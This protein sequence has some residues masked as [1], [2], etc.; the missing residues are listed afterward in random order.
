MALGKVNVNNLNLGQGPVTEIERHFL[1]VGQGDANIG[2]VLS[3][4]QDTDLDVALGINPSEL[5]T[6]IQAA[7]NNG[8]QGWSCS[9][10]PINT[11]DWLTAV[12]VAMD[13]ISPEAIVLVD[14]VADAV[15]IDAIQTKAVS[16]QN[17]LA[18]NV[19]FIIAM[20]GI[21]LQAVPPETWAI[22]TAAMSAIVTGVS[23]NRVLPVPQLHG[24]NV[25]ILAGRLANR[26][27]SIADSPMRIRTGAVL[28]LGAKPVDNDGIELSMAELAAL[29]A[30]RLSVPQWYP[31]YE[32]VYWGD[33]NL[34]EVTGG[35]YQVIEYL[36]PVDSAARKVRVL[37]LAKI[38]DRS[39]NNTAVSNKM[40]ESLF[41]APLRLLSKST[42]F[43][44]EL[45]PGEIQPPKEDAVQIVWESMTA[46]NIYLKVRPYSSPK[47][48]T[49]SLMLD[50]SN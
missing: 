26:A 11:A 14:P 7:K 47:D 42:S 9:A 41:A 21:D 27:A 25:G 44:G 29:D 24:N 32:G 45:L 49:A 15:S 46:V 16:I 13:V 30:M 12:D 19:F 43:N 36:R 37:A 3:I 10:V 2:N 23:A 40:H 38:A 33:G 50:L 8:G 4:N 17:T 39:M 1:F 5:K 20:R 31:D 48:M 35:D 6:Q 18:R 28:S 22:Y 34:L